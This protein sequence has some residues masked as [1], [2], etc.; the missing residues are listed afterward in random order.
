[1]VVVL[2]HFHM[3]TTVAPM[4]ITEAEGLTWL[5]ELVWEGCLTGRDLNFT[6]VS[7]SWACRPGGWCCVCCLSVLLP[8][9]N[10]LQLVWK[11]MSRTFLGCH[12]DSYFKRRAFYVQL[13]SC[14]WMG[15]GFRVISASLG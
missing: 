2:M 14:L 1:M 13:K 4:E 9:A 11:P 8:R 10:S 3:A 12:F 5:A 6:I 7:Q 15:V